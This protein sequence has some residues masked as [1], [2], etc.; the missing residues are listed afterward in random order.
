MADLVRW[1]AE[2]CGR[3]GSPLYAVLLDRLA[4]DVLA[5][6]P[7]AAVLAGHEDDPGP[8]ALALRLAGTVHRLAL[9]GQAPQVAAHFPSTGGDGDADAAWVA[10]RSLLAERGEE[11]RAGLATAPQTNEVGRSAPLL[12]ALLQVAG[13][14]PL[15]VRLWEIGASGG[16]NLRA[17]L[18]TYVAA[19]GGRWGP[20]SSPV[21]LDPAWDTVPAD[22]PASVEVV[23]RVGGDVSPLDPTTPEGALTLESYVWPDQ[24]QRLERLRGAIEVARRQPARL[25]RAGAVDLLHALEP[26][27]GHLTV[28]WH[29]VMWQYLDAEEQAAAAARLEHL[30]QQATSSAPLAHIAFEPR[31]PGPGERHDFLVV[32]TSWPGGAERVLGTAAPHGIPVTWR[33]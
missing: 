13:P 2:A 5:S 25:L 7:A 8:S 33:A 23:E 4:D 6:G 14:E 12:G 10:V 15:P 21:V 29:S 20:P 1:Q 3:L 31:R 28:V 16:L 27:E 32:A 19:D 24:L 9:T 11:V 18:F 30:G 22:A 26:A 17:D